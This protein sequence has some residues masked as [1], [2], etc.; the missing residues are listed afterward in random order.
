MCAGM[1]DKLIDGRSFGIQMSHQS[2]R[3]RHDTALNIIHN[4]KQQLPLIP[5]CFFFFCWCYCCCCCLFIQL[6]LGGED[7]CGIAQALSPNNK[8]HRDICAVYSTWYIFLIVHSALA[9]VYFHISLWCNIIYL[10]LCAWRVVAFDFGM[11]HWC[12]I[13]SI[14]SSQ[15][16]D[17]NSCAHSSIVLATVEKIPQ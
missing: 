7:M 15:Y 10:S 17:D 16:D 8:W 1:N 6:W 5:F 13:C 4:F 2:Y 3:Q 11:V 14:C 12:S 9:I